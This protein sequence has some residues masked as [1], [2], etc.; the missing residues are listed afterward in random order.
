MSFE[1]SEREGLSGQEIMEEELT[2]GEKGEAV[3]FLF[4]SEAHIWTT[5]G[6]G[7]TNGGEQQNG[8]ADKQSEAGQ[9]L[10]GFNLSPDQLQSEASALGI[11]DLFL[12]GHATVIEGR[13]MGQRILQ[14][15]GKPPGFPLTFGP[16]A[17]DPE[18]NRS[19]LSE[20][21][22]SKVQGMA[23]L[24]A[25]FFEKPLSFLK[26][27]GNLIGNPDQERMFFLF[28]EQF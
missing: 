26:F 3:A 18:A 17:N 14:I 4:R 21:D 22:R 27:H 11:S 24:Q 8:Q 1:G 23:W 20:K 6:Y 9:C 28:L 19:V 2:N 25:T 15:G 5:H 10:R 16:D 12:D 13:Q 7:V